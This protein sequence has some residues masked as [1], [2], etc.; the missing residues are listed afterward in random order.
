MAQSR[1]SESVRLEPRENSAGDAGAG[2][3]PDLGMLA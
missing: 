3:N 1:D 2:I